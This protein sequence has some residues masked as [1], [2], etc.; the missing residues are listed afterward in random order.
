MQTSDLS[1]KDAWRII[2]AEQETIVV[3]NQGSLRRRSTS[4]AFEQFAALLPQDRYAVPFEDG[5][6]SA[7]DANFGLGDVPFAMKDSTRSNPLFDASVMDSIFGD[8]ADGK[9]SPAFSDH[10]SV[11]SGIEHESDFKGFDLD[12]SSTPTIATQEDTEVFD[13]FG[14]DEDEDEDEA[15]L[16][17]ATSRPRSASMGGTVYGFGFGEEEEDNDNQG[18]SQYNHKRGSIS[19]ISS[20][21][22]ILKGTTHQTPVRAHIIIDEDAEVDPEDAR[23]MEKYIDGMNH[24]K[25]LKVS[26]AAQHLTNILMLLKKPGCVRECIDIN[27]AVS[28]ASS[29]KEFTEPMIQKLSLQVLALLCATPQG[30]REVFQ[31]Q[32]GYMIVAALTTDELWEQAFRVVR[33][34]LTCYTQDRLVAG[35][36][37]A[38]GSIAPLSMRMFRHPQYQTEILGIIQRLCEHVDDAAA[39]D[40]FLKVLA[41]MVSEEG[42]AEQVTT[43]VLPM[44]AAYVRAVG[45]SAVEH[46]E[47]SGLAAAMKVGPNTEMASGYAGIAS[48]AV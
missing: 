32:V 28:I 30:A 3:D 1:S 11:V 42:V 27:G 5:P 46:V 37:I 40:E 9:D 17:V 7:L 13:G 8:G 19:S 29:V 35:T 25:T 6:L 48:S 39:L 33:A 22:S 24:I 26:E 21:S 47:S 10:E 18:D 20:V 38:D 4:E 43:A 36:L 14:E 45:K 16:S 2:P 41:T 23:K 15:D 31:C 34:A 44:L 12:Q